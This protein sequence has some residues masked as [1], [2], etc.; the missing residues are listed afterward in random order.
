[1]AKKTYEFQN[2]GFSAKVTVNMYKSS[3]NIFT[4]SKLRPITKVAIA[5]NSIISYSYINKVSAEIAQ[6]KSQSIIL[7]FGTAEI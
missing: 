2:T 3:L 7:D 5:T 4:K 1:M 6:N